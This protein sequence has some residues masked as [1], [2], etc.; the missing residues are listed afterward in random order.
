MARPKAGPVTTMPT[1][2]IKPGMKA[3]AWTV[4]E[5][6]TPE[7]VP[8]EILGLW[9]N[10][11]GPGQ[12][13]I[14]GKMGGR[15]Q[16]TNVAAGMSGSPVYIDGKLIGAVSLRIG[17]FSPDSIC[18]ITPIDLMLEINEHEKSR[19]TDARSPDRAAPRAAV[20]VPGELLA[21]VLAAPPAEPV[22]AT[23]IDTPLAFTGFHESAL[24]E[25]APILKQMGLS[26]V[27]GGATSALYSPKPAPGWQT[28]LQ[29]GDPIAGVL[30]SG[31]MSMTGLGTVSYNDGKRI[32]AFGHP[33]FN[34]GPVEMPM[35]KGE[36]VHTFSSSFQP[37]KIG[38]ATGIVGA[39]KQDRHSGIMG[40]LGETA[41]MIPV[42]L[43]VRTY[44]N[45]DQVEKTKQFQFNVFVQQKWTP[46]LMMATL[47]NSIQQT[48][49]FSEEVTYRFNGNVELQGTGGNFNIS[50]MLAPSEMP[51]PP[52]M[53]LAGWWADKFNRLFGNAVQMPKLKSV[54]ATV[55]LLPQ[56]RI[57]TIENAWLA[58]SEVTAGGE[59]SGKVFLRP[60]RGERIARDFKITIPASLPK[61][62]HRLLLSDADTLNRV[63][64]A[65]PSANRF[66]DLP[67]TVSLINQERSNNRLYVSVVENRPTV[68]TDDKTMPSLPASVLNVMQSGQTQNRPFVTAAESASEKLAI[69]FD[70]VVNGSYNLKITV[71]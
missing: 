43:D 14:L 57:A 19:P 34:L 7:P 45:N 64:S 12:D 71:K 69:P 62:D 40:I 21:R 44:G 16:R 65:A 17:A 60:Y 8:I 3:I 1:S 35:A 20:E 46:F 11:W 52:P 50:T 38:N 47:F 42:T 10:N 63:Q 48:N 56:R 59:L 33:F 26:P 61:G 70:L 67:Q 18:G 37:F 54:K 27:Q 15:A 28:A 36:I 5:G 24:R 4:F 31:D 9:K 22:L 29:P 39:L 2:A 6:S 13:I 68:I 51:V 23:P 53:L 41:D 66:M 32:L 30:V 49:E 55:D 58:Q 25:F